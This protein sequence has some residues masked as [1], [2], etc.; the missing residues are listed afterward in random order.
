MTAIDPRSASLV[1]RLQDIEV[2]L[3]RHLASGKPL[4]LDSVAGLH[5]LVRDCRMLAG[6]LPERDLVNHAASGAI[7]PKM[8]E[9]VDLREALAREQRAIQE[10]LDAGLEVAAEPAPGSVVILPVVR[11]DRQEDDGDA[12]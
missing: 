7:G 9:L 12:A 5:V 3:R 6:S 2:M 4:N 8:G 10:R 11:R 1:E